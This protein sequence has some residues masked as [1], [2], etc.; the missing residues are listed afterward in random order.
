MYFRVFLYHERLQATNLGKK[1]YLLL[2]DPFFDREI[3]TKLASKNTYFNLAV[4]PFPTSRFSL[5]HY[6]LHLI[7]SPHSWYF[8]IFPLRLILGISWSFLFFL[9]PH[10]PYSPFYFPYECTI[11]KY[12]F[13]LFLSRSPQHHIIFT[14]LTMCSSI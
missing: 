8:L 12:C 5:T 1:L 2:D 10:S 14:K 4:F 11:S 13:Q 6:F 7:S 3:M 9:L